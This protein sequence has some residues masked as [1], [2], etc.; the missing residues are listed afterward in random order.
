MVPEPMIAD[1]LATASTAEAECVQLVELANSRGGKDNAT[2]V[3]SRYQIAP[4][5]GP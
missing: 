2:A 5:A 3:V 1:A 4:V